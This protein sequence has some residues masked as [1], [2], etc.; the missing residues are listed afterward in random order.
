MD[1]MAGMG[2]RVRDAVERD[3]EFVH[4]IYVPYVLNG[5][6]TFEEMPPG[7]DELGAR[8]ESVIS[9]GLPYLVA[10][11]EG[12]IVGYCYA[13]AYRPRPAYRHTIEDSVYVAEGYGGRGIGSSL[14][15][16]LI[17]RCEAGP[18][19][20]M[21]AVIG[22]SGNEGSMALHRRHGFEPV[23]T[24]RSV[25]FKLGQWIDTVLMQRT[26]GE[27]DRTPPS[28]DRHPEG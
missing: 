22:H 9:A 6:A 5:L 25:G 15:R 2:L 24:L 27:S 21:I 11:S 10:E 13:T 20:Q 4:A 19:R 1:D 14:L 3:L 17:G 7:V 23:G 18:W 26:L 16:E 28:F 12:R 8:R